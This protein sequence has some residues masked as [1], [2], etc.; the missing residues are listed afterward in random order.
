MMTRS[1][2]VG[3]LLIARLTLLEILR[4]RL[5]LAMF[6]LSGLLLGVFALLL[7]STLNK[8]LTNAALN[9]SSIQPTIGLL[10]SGISVTAPSIWLVHLLSSFLTILLAVGMI[11]V[12]LEAGALA[13]LLARPLA[14]AE[15]ILGRWL[16]YV[17]VL[18]IY[19]AL[20]FLAFLGVIALQTGYWPA[21][22]WSALGLLELGQLT[23]LSLALLG[24]CLFSTMANGAL[25]LLLF[26]L[27]LIPSFVEVLTPTPSLTVQHAA[28]IITL[29]MPSDAL[30][31]AASY[32]LVTPTMQSILQGLSIK[33]FDSPFTSGQPITV[34]LLVWMVL[35]CF[36]LPGLAIWRFQRRDV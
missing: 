15:L 2:H 25:V 21:Q 23:L 8:V 32:E 4:R 27:A 17:L 13:V 10:A 7:S 22:A 12:D 14:R 33:T 24:S 20:L 11:S 31:H 28:T 1:M 26:V 18:S 35:Y 6:L 30:W 34:A 9:G 16:G 29:L 3:W 36:A 5:F 19:T